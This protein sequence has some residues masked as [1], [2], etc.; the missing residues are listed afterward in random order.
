VITSRREA[1]QKG[2]GVAL[3][4]RELSVG[5]EDGVKTSPESA[6]PIPLTSTM[7]GAESGPSIV[8]ASLTGSTCT[9]A[10]TVAEPPSPSV[11]V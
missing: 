7:S 11:S 8:G 6:P 1:G 2:R 10:V 3:E 4:D 9:V 5:A